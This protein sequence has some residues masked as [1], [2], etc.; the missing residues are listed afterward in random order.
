M[1]TGQLPSSPFINYHIIWI[2]HDMFHD[3]HPC[4]HYEKMIE[5][6]LLWP[7]LKCAS[8]CEN[9]IHHKMYIPM[10]GLELQSL[11]KLMLNFADTHTHKRK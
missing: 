8:M 6:L 4:F 11:I 9:L 10:T 3:A 7:F 1:K 2:A 5:D